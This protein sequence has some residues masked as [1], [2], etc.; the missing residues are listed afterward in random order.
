VNKNLLF[1]V[2]LI[3]SIFGKPITL[4]QWFM[5]RKDNIC[6]GEYKGV[7]DILGSI[8]DAFDIKI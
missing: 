5:L 7:V 3:G 1:P 6:L 2:S 4:D 8:R